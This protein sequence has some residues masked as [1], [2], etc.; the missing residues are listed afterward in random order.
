MVFEFYYNRI[1]T[2]ELKT[3][4][5]LINYQ[6]THR[7]IV[8]PQVIYF[9]IKERN[10]KEE[11][12]DKEDVKSDVKSKSGNQ[13]KFGLDLDKAKAE[14]Y[15]KSKHEELVEV[16][17]SSTSDLFPS[18]AK[19]MHKF[20]SPYS[21]PLIKADTS[22]YYSSPYSYNQSSYQQTIKIGESIDD[23]RTSC[24]KILKIIEGII[25]TIYNWNDFRMQTL[26][27]SHTKDFSI[28]NRDNINIK[29]E[30]LFKNLLDEYIHK[31]L[32]EPLNLVLETKKNK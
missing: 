24:N 16:I 25:Y 30:L 27:D 31:L 4:Y 29:P 22:T 19:F 13:L 26:V 5:E 14:T 9:K 20:L 11:G 23:Q 7:T 15:E 6:P 3:I 28:E 12:D 10:D 17:K 32:L 21:F 8:D 18:V 2:S 1:K